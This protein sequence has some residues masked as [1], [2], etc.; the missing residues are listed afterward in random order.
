MKQAE[1]VPALRKLDIDGGDRDKTYPSRTDQG[2]L[3][4]SAT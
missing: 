3:V 1:W 4:T 2:E